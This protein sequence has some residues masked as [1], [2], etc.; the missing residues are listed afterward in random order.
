MNICVKATIICLINLAQL[1]KILYY[2]RVGIQTPNFPLIC[3]CL[4]IV[5]VLQVDQVN[6]CGILVCIYGGAKEKRWFCN[7]FS[8]S[9]FMCTLT[10]VDVMQSFELYMNT[11]GW[12]ILPH[13]FLWNRT[14][15]IYTHNLH[16]LR[17]KVPSKQ[18]DW[19]PA[20]KMILSWSC[21]FSSKRF[22]VCF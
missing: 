1:T 10:H 6:M 16:T 15:I 21:L 20:V 9:I 2:I 5:G 12:L 17:E 4:K 7:K 14:Y 22:G 18:I 3:A 19:L 13:E 11:S 8:L